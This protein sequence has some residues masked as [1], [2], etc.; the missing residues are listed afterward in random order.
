MELTLKNVSKK[1]DD[2]VI[3]NEVNYTFE[4]GKIYG[5]L[6][7]NGAGKTTLF[8]CISQN[9]MVDSGEVM[10]SENASYSSTEIGYVY[11]TPH[12]PAFMTGYEFVKYFLEIHKNMIKDPKDPI[13]YL[14]MVGIEEADCHKLMRDYSHGMQNKVQMLTSLMTTPP[15]LLLDEPLTS[16][17]VVASHEM[18]KLLL[19]IKPETIIIFS[20]HILSLAQ[21][22]CDEIVL[23]HNGDIRGIDEADY[24]SPDFEEQLIKILSDN[25][26][27][28]NANA[29][30]GNAFVVG[31]DL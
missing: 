6:G 26:I 2:K 11:A 7:K 22:L 17:D 9:M 27:E 21:D 23:L 4:K 25:A 28:G 31:G 16:F 19:S 20:T 29:I 1:F 13:A 10:L 24:N 30:A 12:L 3:L 15:V 14:T 8:N 18:K 5:L